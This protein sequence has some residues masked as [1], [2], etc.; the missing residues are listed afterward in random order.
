MLKMFSTRLTIS[1]DLSGL[2]ETLFK[3]HLEAQSI[4]VVVGIVIIGRHF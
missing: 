3:S 1:V 4:F 2:D